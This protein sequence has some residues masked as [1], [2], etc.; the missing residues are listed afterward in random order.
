MSCKASVHPY[1][2]TTTRREQK[3]RDESI[4][5]SESISEQ[6]QH[7]INLGET[8]FS[9]LDDLVGGKS[10]RLSSLVTR[11]ELQKKS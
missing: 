7:A 11:V 3:I 5:H 9:Y 6:T 4:V 10:Q 1:G 8:S 2:G